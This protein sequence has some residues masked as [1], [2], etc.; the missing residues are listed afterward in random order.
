MLS[1]TYC[2][3][4]QRGPVEAVDVLS[5]QG[6]VSASADIVHPVVRPEAYDVADS[7]VETRVPVD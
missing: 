4:G 5:G 3:E 2:G 7:E 6:A 1:P